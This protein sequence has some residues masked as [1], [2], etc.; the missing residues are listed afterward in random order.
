M[1]R[2]GYIRANSAIDGDDD[3]YVK[4][5]VYFPMIFFTTRLIRL[6]LVVL[7]MGGNYPYSYCFVGWCF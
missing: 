3:D 1:E 2:V 5:Q 7:E 4:S 6:T